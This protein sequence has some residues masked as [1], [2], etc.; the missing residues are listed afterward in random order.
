MQ[1][2]PKFQTTV[3]KNLIFQIF[4]SRKLNRLIL[5]EEKTIQYK[6]FAD[7]PLLVVFEILI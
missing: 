6:S 5:N 7:D 1:M 2:N 4:F 3:P